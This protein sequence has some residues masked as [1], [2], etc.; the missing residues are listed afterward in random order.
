M[1]ELH[2]NLGPVFLLLDFLAVERDGLGLLHVNFH[3]SGLLLLIGSEHL[4]RVDRVVRNLDVL[5]PVVELAQFRFVLDI[6]VIFL[7]L[8]N[9]QGSSSLFL[10]L[11][12]GSDGIAFAALTRLHRFDFVLL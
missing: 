9:E 3:V 5:H 7:G 12:C 11:D 8:L 10:A 6:H 2:G 4:Q 1:A